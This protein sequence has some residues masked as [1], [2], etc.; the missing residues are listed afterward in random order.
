M[1]GKSSRTKGHTWERQ[2]ARDLREVMPGEEIKR[3]FQSRFGGKEE[4]DVECPLFHVEAKCAQSVNVWAAMRQAEED[5]EARGLKKT[6]VV[7][8]KRDA[9]RDAPIAVL[10]YSDWLDMVKERHFLDNN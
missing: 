7:I 10:R 5:A 6:P 2:I 9:R 1:G 8:V 4:A 3:G